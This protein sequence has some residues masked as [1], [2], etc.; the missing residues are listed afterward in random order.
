MGGLRRGPGYSK[1]SGKRALKPVKRFDV[2][3]AEQD[4]KCGICA[5]PFTFNRRHDALVDHDHRTGKVRGLLCNSCNTGLGKMGDSIVG[6]ERA[7]A[8]LRRAE[9]DLERDSVANQVDRLPPGRYTAVATAQ[10]PE[11]ADA[12]TDGTPP[13]KE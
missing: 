13:A 6:L 11:P 9:V 2:M 7:I 8:Y 1:V 5:R 4:G 12:P 10:D 3:L